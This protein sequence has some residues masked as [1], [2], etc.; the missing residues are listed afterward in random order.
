MSENTV[1]TNTT[2][3]PPDAADNP[4]VQ[5]IVEFNRH[6][7][8][9][10]CGFCIGD[11]STLRPIWG[12]NYVRPTL[13][14]HL[15]DIFIS[16]STIGLN[17]MTP[18]AALHVFIDP[19]DIDPN[20]LTKS[21]N[22][23]DWRPLR[24]IP[25]REPAEVEYVGDRSRVAARENFVTWLRETAQAERTEL[26]QELSAI[27]ALSADDPERATR[28]HAYQVQMSETLHKEQIV[29]R[30]TQWGVA[31]FDAG[32]SPCQSPAELS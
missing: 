19:G 24:Y 31:V 7:N 17:F 14:S 11:A 28:F 22:P 20:C 32:K 3:L 5:D 26:I 30:S 13:Q 8:S 9:A 25:G 15:D 29:T 12:R 23:E 4:H 27:E 1:N 10:F 2:T 6:V 18:D 16:F 21:P